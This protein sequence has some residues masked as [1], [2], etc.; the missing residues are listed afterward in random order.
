MLVE[1]H[2]K[3]ELWGLA[4]HPSQP[5]VATGGDDGTLRLWSVEPG[6]GRTCLERARVVDNPKGIKSSSFDTGCLRAVAFHPGG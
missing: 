4:V 5:R 1:G 3:G 6:K 2:G